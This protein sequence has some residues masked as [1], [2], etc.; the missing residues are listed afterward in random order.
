[1]GA[2]VRHT[3]HCIKIID[4]HPDFHGGHVVICLQLTMDTVLPESWLLED[5]VIVC[6]Q[7]IL[8]DR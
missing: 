4:H 1:M 7:I 3:R 6:G 5:E 8:C 2:L